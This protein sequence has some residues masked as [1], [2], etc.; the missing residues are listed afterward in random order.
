MISQK[1]NATFKRFVERQ[2]INLLTTRDGEWTLF[3]SDYKTARRNGVDVTTFSRADC[4][5]Y[6]QLLEQYLEQYR[7]L[8][9]SDDAHRFVFVTR[10]GQRFGQS[11]FSDFV[12]NLIHKHSGIRMSINLIR[13]S[14]ISFFYDS[15]RS[16]DMVLRESVAKVMRHSRR[17]AERTYDRRTASQRKRSGLKLLSSIAS[18]KQKTKEQDLEED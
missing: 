3:L 5:W 16:N 15:D 17:E 10:S 18:K 7:P 4:G 14:F 9:V 1:G 6:I 11:Y 2:N 8:L 13:S 12:Q